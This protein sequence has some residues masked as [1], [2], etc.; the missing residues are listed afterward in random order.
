MD[1]AQT[2]AR[3]SDSIS[4]HHHLTLSS[5]YIVIVTKSRHLHYTWQLGPLAIQ[6]C[7]L[8]VGARLP[9]MIHASC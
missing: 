5:V 2:S 8:S 7:L 6:H 1:F 4:V 9:R 3:Q